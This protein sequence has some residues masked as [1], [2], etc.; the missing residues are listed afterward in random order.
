MAGMFF[1]FVSSQISGW[2]LTQVLWLTAAA[3]SVI[4]CQSGQ[5]NASAKIRP[6]AVAGQFYSDNPEKLRSALNYY[7]DQAIPDLGCDPQIIIVPHAGYI[8]SGQI[9]ADAFSQI[10]RSTPELVV[11]LGTNHTTAGADQV[12]F[13]TGAGYET[14][15]GI[16]PINQDITQQLIESSPLFTYRPE[17]HRK[18]HSVEVQI[19]FIQ[20][21]F[22]KTPIVSAIVG[23][24]DSV[25]CRHLANSLHK[26]LNHLDYLVIASSDLSHYPDYQTACRVDSLTIRQIT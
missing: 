23:K 18:E 17:M 14:P 3:V 4:Q 24:P 19:P 2:K 12:S 25:L 1:R 26:H 10:R 21:L 16:A 6:P 7:L 9:T 20:V 22:P 13:F 11:I 5:T 15:L 8:Y